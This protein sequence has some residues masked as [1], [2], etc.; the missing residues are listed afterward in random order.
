MN[1]QIGVAT[2]TVAM[3]SIP[4]MIGVRAI[5]ID[6]QAHRGLGIVINEQESEWMVGQR[7]T[8]IRGKDTSILTVE[9]TSQQRHI[10]APILLDR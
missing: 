3:A 1:H 2:L 10:L 9:R 8:E 6:A 4:W 7:N 5:R